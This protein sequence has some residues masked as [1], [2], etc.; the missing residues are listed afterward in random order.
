MVTRQVF[1]ALSKALITI[2]VM[3]S[4][5]IFAAGPVSA[6]SAR[7]IVAVFLAVG[8]LGLVALNRTKNTRTMSRR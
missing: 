4:V 6:S 8:T 3:L 7:P 2:S 1:E 5:L